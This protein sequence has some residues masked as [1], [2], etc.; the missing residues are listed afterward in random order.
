MISITIIESSEQAFS[1]IFSIKRI[2]EVAV[3]VFL[4]LRLPRITKQAFF[5]LFD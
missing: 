1:E 2:S 5:G 4:H 3:Y